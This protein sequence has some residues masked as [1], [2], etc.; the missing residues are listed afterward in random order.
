MAP[1]APMWWFKEVPIQ[2][3]AFVDT[4]NSVIHSVPYPRQ[5]QS[6]QPQEYSRNTFQNQG[7]VFAFPNQYAKSVVWR[8]KDN[9]TIL[10]LISISGKENTLTRQIS[11]QFHAPILPGLHIA[12]LAPHGGIA[13]ALLT[14]DS[15]L[16]KLHISALSHFITKDAPQRY[17]SAAQVKW[18]TNA[19]PLLFKYLGDRQASVAS[20]DGALFL[21]KTALLAEDTNR[22]GHAEVRVF[23]L[24]DDS[25]HIPRIQDVTAIQKIRSIFQSGHDHGRSF[26]A[27][28]PEQRSRMDILA[29]ETYTTHDD[30]LLFALYQDRTIRVW[31]MG[32]RQCL[33]VMRS[34]PKPNNSGYVQ[35]TIDTSSRAHL[36]IMFNP[37][38]PWV[39]RL[40]VYIPTESEA[41][42][43]VYTSRLDTAEDV[44]FVQGSVSTIRPESTAGHGSNPSNLVKMEINLNDNQ[45]GYTVWG[46]WESDMRISAKYMQIDDP[47]MER[48]HYQ[49]FARRDLLDSRWWPVAMQ[50]PL[51][52]FVKSMS[53]VDDSV[54]D[55]SHYYAEIVFSSGRFSDRTIMRTLKS[56]FED[57][58]FELDSDLQAHVIEAMSVIPTGPSGGDREYKRHQ[59]IMNWTR[60][61]SHCAKLDHEAS[62]PLGLSIATDT[63]YMIVVK[64]DV[65]SFF[66]AC[67]DSEILYH[68][69]QDKQFEVAQFI[70]T[71]Q[72][73]LRNTYP[74][75]QD[76]SL[77]NDVSKVFRAI[78]FLTHNITV[79]SS[80]NLEAI[81][82]QL[83]SANGPRNFI[84]ALSQ[85][86]LPNFIPK[87]DMNRARNMVAS[88][89]APTDA[90]RF[91]NSQLL[92]S[93]DSSP[94]GFASHR[95]ILPYE[96]LVA[97]SIQQLAANRYTMAQNFLI[98][99]AVIFSAPP[100]TRPWIQ[101]ETEFVSDALRVT[102]SLLILKWI[103][104]QT[105][106]SSSPTSG[107]ER[108]L[109]QMQV[110]EASLN[111]TEIAYRQSLTG[112]LLKSMSSE[113]NI[114]GAVEFPI[115]LAIPRAVSKF[116]YGLG[117]M[118]QGPDEDSKYHAGLAQRL[119]GRGAMTLLSQFLDI[120]PTTSSLSYYRGKVL[121]NQGKPALAL[122]QFM[123]VT[124]AFGN[125]VG[126]V[127]QELDIMQLD[128]A[129]GVIRGHAK[130]E[131]YYNNVITLFAESNAHEQVIV[132]ARLA[133]SDLL[134]NAKA[135]VTELQVRSLLERIIH[136]ALSI[137]SYER[138]FN[139]MMLI[140]NE[141][142]R[143]QILKK[144]VS[145]ICENGDGAKL[146]LFTFGALQ[147]DVERIL[148]SNA[149]QGAV[150]SRPDHYKVLYAYYIYKGEYKKG[151]T[152]M[153]QYVRRLCD[154]TNRTESIWNLLA[155][156]GSA[157]LAAI[158][159]LHLAGPSNAWV[160]IPFS[161]ADVESE[162]PL[163][164]RRLGSSVNGS[165]YASSGSDQRSS[166]PHRVEIVQLSD[167]KQ[168]F[169]L[170]KAKLL[171]VTDIPSQV[172]AGALTMTPRET[173]L[174]LVQCGNYEVA[175]SLALLHN[176][177]LDIVFKLLVDKYMC[178]LKLEQ[179]ELI[180]QG[181][182][183]GAK[184]IHVDR[185]RSA[186]SLQTM[187]SYLKRHD[188]ASSNY[189]Y[190]LWV[191]ECILTAN[192]DFDLQPWLSQHYLTHNPEDLI[193]LYL[194]FGAL[195]K[196][197]KFALVVIEAAMK[198]DELI[199]RHSNARW[200]PYSLLDEIF[201][202]LNE[203]IQRA[204]N[205]G[206]GNKVATHTINAKEAKM[207]HRLRE[208]KAL[209]VQLDENVRL[210]LENVERESI[211]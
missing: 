66:T 18:T 159:A 74:K 70:A 124:A 14:A 42:L 108:Q 79:E 149:E 47:S 165:S 161:A 185:S 169:A 9:S 5:I 20:T 49:Q 11:F 205:R 30:T 53:A 25:H 211:F 157:C 85:E 82:A 33:Q 72:S 86:H 89:K 81:I 148:K 54:Q 174:L 52:G 164:R 100:S 44:E 170:I 118:N 114:Y 177:D 109:S 77:R 87:T 37:Q 119:S 134:Q 36:G 43:I 197:A 145:K 208:L 143:K 16:Y 39:L 171:L 194:K 95:C 166:T 63:G 60:F 126:S 28:F 206:L 204:Q 131:D 182:L 92:H 112:S 142:L 122:E 102:Q 103:S 76:A 176:L 24:H 51:T 162:E 61:I 4:Q 104:N 41:Q 115:Y 96:A 55:V 186:A 192:P 38:M 78:S 189:K 1:I 175:T 7:G 68:T 133:L 137:G 59:E 201:E 173:Q 94:A 105:I 146:A 129:T 17:S 181:G 111:N 183:R 139:A 98:L 198:K 101:E 69:F 50:A 203:Q 12:A 26:P 29:M 75:L 48:E 21:I 13:I 195:E 58:S 153:C 45:T 106:A 128:Y 140:S 93:A 116:L 35:E 193:R 120:V 136:A 57:R 46:L 32:R 210:Y 3:E 107:L 141:N 168:E 56:L 110:H 156:A 163:K 167:L 40:L 121:L 155:E 151:A 196:A 91:L 113:A 99:L 179:D 62:T 125:D 67:D 97:S 180:G 160:S 22:H 65:L 184:S 150:L 71:P 152:I 31:S 178:D 123:A 187:Q 188:S 84:D 154:G 117:I 73:Q 138:A 191:I 88:C 172:V 83:S 202:E 199:S 6:N 90:F 135:P 207:E 27:G 8:T 2:L 132:V 158:N 127:E 19:T 190:R 34:T 15:V 80:K 144:F 147:D 10:E 209:K 64:Q 23:D 200:L 130:V